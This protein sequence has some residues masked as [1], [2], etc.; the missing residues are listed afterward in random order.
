MQEFPSKVS[1]FE[2]SRDTAFFVAVKIKGLLT[3]SNGQGRKDPDVYDGVEKVY[4]AYT[5]TSLFINEGSQKN[6]NGARNWRQE[7]MQRPQRNA[8]YWLAPPGLFSLLPYNQRTTCIGIVSHTMGL[9]F[10][11]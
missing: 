10:S 3:A 6:A 1:A 2:S 8:A 11:H 9:A 7:L 4:L 5:F